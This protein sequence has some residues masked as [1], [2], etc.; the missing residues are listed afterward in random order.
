ME[1]Q[2][3]PNDAN[4]LGAS[5]LRPDMGTVSC[6]VLYRFPAAATVSD[7]VPFEG[8]RS[9]CPASPRGPRLLGTCE[10]S[11]AAGGSSPERVGSACEV[12]PT[13]AAWRP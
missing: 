3:A 1:A 2:F 9:A 13:G 12:D 8:L 11:C 6:A 10:N 4:G 7:E 5:V